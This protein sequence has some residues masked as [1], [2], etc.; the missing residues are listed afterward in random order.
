[1]PKDRQEHDV[2]EGQREGPSGWSTRNKGR[3]GD[4]G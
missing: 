3:R 2:S 4:C 1:M